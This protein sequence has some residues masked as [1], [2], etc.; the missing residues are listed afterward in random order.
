MIKHTKILN[1]FVFILILCN[2]I[3]ISAQNLDDDSLKKEFKKSLKFDSWTG[4]SNIV[5]DGINLS[6]LKLTSLQTARKIV[7]EKNFILFRMENG[8]H[9]IKHVGNWKIGDDDF[10]EI[11]ISYL[12]SGI[13]AHEYVI[14]H[15]FIGSALP[16][17]MKLNTLDQPS[18]IGDVSFFGGRI[19]IKNNIVVDIHAE[20]QFKSNMVQIAKEIDELLSSQKIYNSCDKVKP[21][22][23]K[24]DNGKISIIEP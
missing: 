21:K 16:L 12:N 6:A 24:D 9:F 5:R 1:I 17:S 15:Y 13:E 23:K 10:L 8:E 2:V 3:N 20:G 11:T 18:V 19:F 4:K 22:L 7:K 14:D